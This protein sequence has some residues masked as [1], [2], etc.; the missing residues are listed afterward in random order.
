MVSLIS[1]FHSE[2]YETL[3]D[4]SKYNWDYDLGRD[5]IEVWG[6]FSVIWDFMK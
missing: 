2:D 6:F 4:Y 1:S 5:L 3:L